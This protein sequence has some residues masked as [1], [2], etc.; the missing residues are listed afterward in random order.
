MRWLSVCTRKAH[1]PIHMP[2]RLLGLDNEER[3][4]EILE[5][6]N[7]QHWDLVI[8]TNQYAGNF[9]RELCAWV[10]GVVGDCAVG[11]HEKEQFLHDLDGTKWTYLPYEGAS[12]KNSH[13]QDYL[14]FER[15]AHGCSRPVALYP[16][17]EGAEEIYCSLAIKFLTRPSDEE[18]DLILSRCH[19]FTYPGM[20]ILGFRLIS[21]HIVKTKVCVL[22]KDFSEGE[23]DA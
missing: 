20:K 4:R 3:Q 2:V 9:E 14:R 1:L 21:T 12:E 11:D 19:T 16:S 10:T 23:E 6:E 18:L 17:L 13:F 8:D 15:D 7:I 5:I 22:K